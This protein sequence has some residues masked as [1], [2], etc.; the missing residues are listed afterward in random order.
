MN[1]RRKA[2]TE[3]DTMHLIK[4]RTHPTDEWTTIAEAPTKTTADA[5]ADEIHHHITANHIQWTSY[6][7]TVTP[8][9]DTNYQWENILGMITNTEWEWENTGGGCMVMHTTLEDG[10]I[11]MITDNT[12]G[13]TLS[14]T[15]EILLGIYPNEESRYTG[16]GTT[17]EQFS[18]M[19]TMIT[20]LTWRI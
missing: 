9:D 20:A 6:E 12:N 18:N 2:P 11:L 10:R 5:L 13:D 19:A 3:R 15:D 14:P 16:E 8:K 4:Y 1:Q 7:V 17:Y